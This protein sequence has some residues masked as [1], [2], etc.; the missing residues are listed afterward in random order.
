MI[1]LRRT[2]YFFLHF[3]TKV[4]KNFIYLKYKKKIWEKKITIQILIII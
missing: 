2:S 4:Y 3:G 1:I